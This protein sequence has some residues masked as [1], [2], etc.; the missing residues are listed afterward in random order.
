ME[1]IERQYRVIST[2]H[3]SKISACSKHCSLCEE[4][5]GFFKERIANKYFEKQRTTCESSTKP[6]S[7][8]P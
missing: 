7:G 8:C 3:S 4:E 2:D 5:G 1:V 6:S